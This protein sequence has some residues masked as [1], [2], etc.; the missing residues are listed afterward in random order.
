MA[1]T[2]PNHET[3]NASTLHHRGSAVSD[4]DWVPGIRVYAAATSTAPHPAISNVVSN[5]PCD[6]LP[7]HAVP[8]NGA[9]GTPP[10]HVPPGK[11]SLAMQ[12][13]GSSSV[14]FFNTR[15]VGTHNFLSNAHSRHDD[16]SSALQCISP[17]FGCA[18]FVCMHSRHP[19]GY[20]ALTA[21]VRARPALRNSCK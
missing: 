19:A 10:P 5:Q 16:R 1:V 21:A 13:T 20:L 14:H 17:Q 18:S 4:L 12:K 2:K 6:Q 11:T 9:R 15:E 3:G 7:S 8:N